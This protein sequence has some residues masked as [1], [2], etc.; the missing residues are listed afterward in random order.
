MEEYPINSKSDLVMDGAQEGVVG[1]LKKWPEMKTKLHICFNQILPEKL[2]QI[3][4]RLFLENMRGYQI[5]I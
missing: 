1:L 3:A 2:R 4:W 5:Y